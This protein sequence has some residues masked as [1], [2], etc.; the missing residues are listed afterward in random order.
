MPFGIEGEYPLAKQKQQYYK[1][2]CS[3]HILK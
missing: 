3:N 1:D 2:D